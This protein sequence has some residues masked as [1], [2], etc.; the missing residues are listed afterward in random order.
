MLFVR[1]LSAPVLLRHLPR[2]CRYGSLVIHAT[3]PRLSLK[4][5]APPDATE[6]QL[7]MRPAGVQTPRTSSRKRL[8]GSSCKSGCGTS[9]FRACCPFPTLRP[10]LTTGFCT[11]TPRSPDWTYQTAMHYINRF[12]LTRSI[13]K[14]DRHVSRKVVP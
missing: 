4:K 12:Y 3:L 2:L 13:S 11:W 5:P 10:D 6:L 7:M 14:N 9:Q 1:G 8:K